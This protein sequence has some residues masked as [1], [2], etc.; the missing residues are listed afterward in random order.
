MSWQKYVIKNT[1]IEGAR[2]SF[3]KDCASLFRAIYPED[4]VRRVEVKK[5]DGGIDIFIGEIGVEPITVIQCKFFLYEFGYSQHQ[6]ISNSFK[7]ALESNDY[8]FNKWM[9]CIPGT[10]DLKENLW[11]S[12]WA[13]KQIKSN[14][15]KKGSILL[16]DGDALIDLFKKYGLFNQVFGNEEM[17][18][19]EKV[20]NKVDLLLD[21]NQISFDQAQLEIQKGS[22]YLEEVSNYFGD[23]TTSHLERSETVAIF[24]WIKKDLAT[25]EK[26]TFILEAEKGYGKTVI[27]KDLLLKL[28]DE[29][30]DALG[31]KADKYYAS[32][33][34]NLEQIIFQKDNVHLEDIAK[35]YNQKGRLLVIIIDQLDALSQTLSSN[36]EYLQTYNRLIADMAYY[37]NIR[38]II[39]TRSFDL[40]YDAEISMYKKSEYSKLKVSLISEEKVKEILVKYNIHNASKKLLDLLAVPNH[41][42]IFCRIPDKKDRDT[43][44]SLKDLFDALWD[45]LIAQK[46][47]LSLKS[48]LYKIAER[49]YLQQQI[50]TVNLYDDFLKEINYLKSNSLLIESNKELQ[51]FHQTFYDY[52]FA[53][54]FVEGKKSLQKY[55]KENRQSLYVRSVIKMVVEYYRE[56]DSA[57]YIRLVKLLISSSY[58][59]FHIK[60]LIISS[61]AAS[62]NPS[63]KELDIALKYIIPNFTY[64]QLFGNQIFSSA[65][66]RF[67]LENDLLLNFII[68]PKK[69]PHKLHAKLVRSKIINAD[70]KSIHNFEFQRTERLNLS[71]RLLVNN[72]ENDI[73]QI[74]DYLNKIPDFEGKDNFMSRFLTNLKDWHNKRLLPLFDIYLAYD[75]SDENRENFWFFDT[76]KKIGLYHIDFV[77][78][79]IE[80][81]IIKSFNDNGGYVIFPYDQISLYDQINEIYP[82]KSFEFFFQIFKNLIE[83]GKFAG[84][85]EKVGCPFY[86]SDHFLSDYHDDNK[87]QADVYIKNVIVNYVK[88]KSSDLKYFSVFFATYKNSNS[89]DLLKILIVG[90]LDNREFYK[91]EIFELIEIIYLKRGFNAADDHFQF[92]LVNLLSGFTEIG[93]EAAKEKVIEILLSIR[94]PYEIFLHTEKDTGIKTFESY[95]GQ[96]QYRYLDALPYDFRDNIVSL[97]K[98]HQELKRRYPALKTKKVRR[99]RITWYSVGPPI[100]KESCEKMSLLDW[101]NTIYK[102]NDSYV[103]DRRSANSRG[104]K[105]EHC[106]SF[107]EI[108][109]A[110]AEKYYP[111]LIELVN[112]VKVSPDYLTSGINGLIASNYNVIK[113]QEL[114][115]LHINRELDRYN[116]LCAIRNIDYFISNKSIDVKLIEFLSDILLKVPN[117]DEIKEYSDPLTAS[118]NSFR[119]AATYRIICSC[120]DDKFIESVFDVL[121]RSVCDI[122][123]GVKAGIFYNLAYLDKFDSERAFKIFLKLIETDDLQLLRNAFRPAYHFRKKFN[124]EMKP[125]FNRII[126]NE[127][128]HKDGS[129]LLALNWL[130]GIEKDRTYLNK[131]IVKGK[132]GKLEL[133]RAAESKIFAKKKLDPKCLDIFFEFLHEEDKEFASAYSGFILRKFKLIH[134]DELLPFMKKYAKSKLF[135]AEPRYFLNFL[136]E[137]SKDRPIDCLY[138]VKSMKF[139]RVPNVQERGHYDSEPVQLILAIY[140]TLNNH[141]KNHKGQIETTLSIFDNMLQLD[142]LRFSAG[143]ALEKL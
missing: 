106:N 6:Q 57:E 124:I 133:L 73:D 64:T 13:E 99:S 47:D 122:E 105:T 17:L 142:H 135:V 85:Y 12:N 130:S 42:D 72:S 101:K 35:L 140:S 32:N 98:I 67:I 16:R 116:K 68:Y 50:I 9:L 102:Y 71:L 26:N 41:L 132:T 56:Y 77:F 121:E 4:G 7:T 21:Q 111:F 80:P 86:K 25:N 112:D 92:Y 11:W 49:M 78:Q 38:I 115:H 52:T 30:I 1:N 60:S 120:Y 70:Y 82:D 108:V 134:F 83:Q 65:W 24:D 44:S 34:V 59:R 40:N 95:F 107:Q 96:K 27:L 45:Q 90:L 119:G 48:I 66:F 110:N 19:I 53:R 114:F 51:F 91:A 39:S 22:F 97:R 29:G 33:R 138:L 129:S 74:L 126:E 136:L 5:G 84:Y 43:L 76:L 31:I 89:V 81:L 69:W 28:R 109:T 14:Q 79:K 61:F 137:C 63:K 93:D 94:D 143:V 10:L 103:R 15:L 46:S 100:S 118:L 54:Q 8:E 75:F 113:V 3:E 141:F 131:L 104:G 55:I 87:E 23:I 62:T 125:F 2:A 36:R 128:L 20:G 37:V 123:V 18:Q 139:T 117:I 88:N 127:E 58:Y